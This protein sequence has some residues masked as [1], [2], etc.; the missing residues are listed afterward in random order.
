[1]LRFFLK[2]IINNCLHRLVPGQRGRDWQHGYE[3]VAGD[4]PRRRCRG[5]EYCGKRASS[6]A[7]EGEGI[8]RLVLLIF[9]Q[10]TLQVAVAVHTDSSNAGDQQTGWAKGCFDLAAQR[11]VLSRL[12]WCSNVNIFSP[13]Q[14][15]WYEQVCVTCKAKTTAVTAKVGGVASRCCCDC[16]SRRFVWQASTEDVD[17]KVAAFSH[18]VAASEKAKPAGANEE[19]ETAGT[20]TGARRKRTCTF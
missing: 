16:C 9:S 13:R 1:M 2:K 12:I 14:K 19:V 4:L 15:G 7:A 10:R 11:W 6:C 17:R 3:D 20:G 5:N 18:A 8:I